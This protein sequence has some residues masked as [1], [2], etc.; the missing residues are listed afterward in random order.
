MNAENA[1]AALAGYTL[2]DS[3]PRILGFHFK[4]FGEMPLVFLFQLS[5][6]RFNT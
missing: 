1:S 5:G 3:V 6:Q 4:E 2:M